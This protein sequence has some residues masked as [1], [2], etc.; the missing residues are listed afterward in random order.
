M[1]KLLIAVLLIGTMRQNALAD[2]TSSGL[3]S[4][5]S[6]KVEVR[7]EPAGPEARITIINTSTQALYV[8]DVDPRELIT[9]IVGGASG[10]LV[11]PT[12]IIMHTQ[13]SS[14]RSLLKLQPGQRYVVAAT[15]PEFGNGWVSLA[16][17]GYPDVSRG[18]YTVTA[19]LGI[20]FGG[21]S[22]V[23]PYTAQEAK[24]RPSSIS[25]VVRINDGKPAE[26]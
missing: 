14:N 20:Y 26:E 3:R 6:L 10:K 7:Q 25:T 21:M 24:V 22:G 9:V 8:S 1:I 4:P 13:S 12:K 18:R 2:D 5:V 11:E 16:E 17:W 23:K 19:R 15:R